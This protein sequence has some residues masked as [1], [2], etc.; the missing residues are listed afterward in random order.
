MNSK[1]QQ[2]RNA[3]MVN[4]LTIRTR[5]RRTPFPALSTRYSIAVGAPCCSPAAHLGQR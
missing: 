2:T 1:T 4:T 5:L 3:P